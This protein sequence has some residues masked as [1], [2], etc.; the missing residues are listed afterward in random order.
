MCKKILLNNKGSALAMVIII[1][2]ILS[3]LGMAVMT[4]GV[5]NLR[6]S[7]ADQKLNYH[8]IWQNQ[9]WSRLMGLY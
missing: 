5:V 6:I 9:V 2:T 1:I 4:L 8:S 3:T 7:I